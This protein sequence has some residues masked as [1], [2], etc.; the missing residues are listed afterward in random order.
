MYTIQNKYK[1]MRSR[2]KRGYYDNSVLDK[3]QLRVILLAEYLLIK[4]R[5]NCALIHKCSADSQAEMFE[6]IFAE[7]CGR[8]GADI[9]EAEGQ[10]QA[11]FQRLGFLYGVARR[12]FSSLMEE[13]HHELQ[14]NCLAETGYCAQL[15]VGKGYSAVEVTSIGYDAVMDEN[16]SEDGAASAADFASPKEIVDCARSV[17]SAAEMERSRILDE[18]VIQNDSDTW[19][20][21]KKFMQGKVVAKGITYWDLWNAKFVIGVRKC[22][23]SDESAAKSLGLSRKTFIKYF[24]QMME[25]LPTVPERF[26]LFLEF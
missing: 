13:M 8:I 9:R 20:A 10:A 6:S 17:S 15:N 26:G 23:V 3:G 4:D 12:K 5:A 7:L 2:I 24:G 19:K 16:E 25:E 1:K 21:I 22:Q 18:Y 11:N 14:R